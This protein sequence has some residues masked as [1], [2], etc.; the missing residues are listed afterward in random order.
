MAETG[1]QVLGDVDFDAGGSAPS[2][3]AARGG[4]DKVPGI[5]AVEADEDLSVNLGSRGPES[6]DCERGQVSNVVMVKQ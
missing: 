3:Q 2:R 6:L 1:F 5:D 4:F